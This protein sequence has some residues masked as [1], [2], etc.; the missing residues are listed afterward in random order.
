VDTP[1]PNNAHLTPLYADAVIESHYINP[2]I[3]FKP[4]QTGLYPAKQVFFLD[5]HC[6]FWIE[7]LEA[8]VAQDFP[9]GPGL[10]EMYTL[11]NMH[12]H[13]C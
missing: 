8:I 1:S 13:C 11:N 9:A 2:Y 12:K 10:I 5:E 6:I 4:K 3:N 7:N